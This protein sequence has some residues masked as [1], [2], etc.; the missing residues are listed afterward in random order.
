MNKNFHE[1]NVL[2]EESTKDVQE[3]IDKMLEDSEKET[4]S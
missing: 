3:E 2:D 1:M 4:E